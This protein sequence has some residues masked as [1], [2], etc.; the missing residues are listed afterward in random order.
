MNGITRK[1][2]CAKKIES[3][4]DERSI[5]ATISTS[6]VDRDKEVLLP[7]GAILDFYRKN[8]VVLWSH[9]P[10]VP[11]IGKTKW[12][13]KLSDRII[14]KFVFPPIGVSQKAD[15]IYELYKGGFLNA[16]SVGFIPIESRIPTDEDIKKNRAWKN[17][18]KIISKWEM[19][20]FSGV[21]IPAN[22]QALTEAVKSHKLNLSEEMQTEFNIK[23]QNEDDTQC[24]IIDEIDETELPE[25]FDDK[26]NSLPEIKDARIIDIV[27]VRPVEIPVVEIEEKKISH[28]DI[29]E[30]AEKAIY[31]R[32][33]KSG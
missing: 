33:G 28:K 2:F 24:E 32:L 18:R 13:K 8:P 20:E 16:F 12:I 26:K 4:D 7:S 14:A 17:A 21:A 31:R 1:Q 27:D 11:P 15:E 3:L 23:I 25:K 22:P 6:D 5:T 10:T 29:A 19:Y 30:I 9:N